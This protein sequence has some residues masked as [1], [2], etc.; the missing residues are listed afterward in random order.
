MPEVV[1]EVVTR[2]RGP[3]AMGWAIWPA[4]STMHQSNSPKRLMHDCLAAVVEGRLGGV[5]GGK[6]GE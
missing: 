2:S 5:R 1:L 6:G 4:S 3:R